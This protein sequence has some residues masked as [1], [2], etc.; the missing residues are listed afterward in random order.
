MAF[1]S[2][3][4]K[5]DGTWQFCLFVL[6]LEASRATFKLPPSADHGILILE[7]LIVCVGAVAAVRELFAQPAAVK[8]A[9][10]SK[11]TT[12]PW[13]PPASLDD[14]APTW[15]ASSPNSPDEDPDDG[16]CIIVNAVPC[17]PKGVVYK[18]NSLEPCF[19]DSGVCKGE[20]IFIHRPTDRPDKMKSGHYPY[21]DHMHD[22][23]RLWE[24]RIQM[25]FS[26][27]VST[28]DIYF[29]C[30]QDRYYPIG[31]VERYVSNSVISLLRRAASGM[32]QSHGDDPTTTEGEPER[33]AVVFPL[34]VMDQLIQ[35]PEGEEPPSILDP[36]FSGMGITK[37]DDRNA[38]KEAID[39]LEFL[40]GRTYTFGFWC[41]A[42]FVDA[43]GWKVPPRG[44]LPET[45]LAGLGTHP[46]CYISMYCLRPRQEWRF[47]KGPDDKRH[48]DSRKK[49][50][51]RIG[52]WSSKLPPNKERLKDLTRTAT[53]P[54]VSKTRTRRKTRAWCCG[55]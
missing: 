16:K 46:P 52:F 43:I 27:H 55:G 29:G 30:E 26:Q 47:V 54:P 9:A 2:G 39:A 12:G 15:V 19:F 21:S 17:G 8:K 1:A 32:Y 23:R 51:L 20:Y 4:P 35:T 14:N 45:H 6:V 31:P 10:A 33:P 24:F 5:T 11:G 22:R 28:R 37:N 18:T 34:W 3:P 25:T 50:L 41:I 7:A 44:L 36:E 53:S 40:P 49:Y 38:M 13:L 42:Q 48:L